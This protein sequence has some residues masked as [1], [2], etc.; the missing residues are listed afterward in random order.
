[1]LNERNEVGAFL[2]AESEWL[3][4]FSLQDVK[5]LI[6]CRGPV[7]KEAFDIFNEIG[8]GESGILLSQKDSIVYPRSLAPELRTV[9]NANVHRVV[10]YMGVGQEEKTERIGEIIEI[11]TSNGYSHI[12]A[13]Y[14][15]MAEDAEFIEAIENAGLVFI[16]PSSS[17]CR[18]AGAKDEAKK[19][20]RGL[21]NAVIPGVDNITPQALLKKAGDRAA[22]EALAAEH[23]LAFEF[24]IRL[25]ELR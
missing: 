17:V 23:D 7:R 9:S 16:G 13:G 5:C 15:F 3:R 20:A 10:D 25:F 2:E 6:V 1:V 19:L 18:M 21:G 14:G 4:S 12:F 11:A 22:L 8:V 24:E